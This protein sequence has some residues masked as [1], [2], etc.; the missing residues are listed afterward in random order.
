MASTDGV[1]SFVIENKATGLLMEEDVKSGK[2][3]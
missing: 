1:S 3:I 2:K